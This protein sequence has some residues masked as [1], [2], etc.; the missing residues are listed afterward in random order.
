MNHRYTDASRKNFLR[1]LFDRLLL[2][3]SRNIH[4]DIK[5]EANCP[6]EFVNLNFSKIKQNILLI[7][8]KAYFIFCAKGKLSVLLRKQNHYAD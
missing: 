3:H 1:S 7:Y 8:L 6:N 2:R 5:I 4:W